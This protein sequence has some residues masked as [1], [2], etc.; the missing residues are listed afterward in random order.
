MHHRTDFTNLEA[1][2]R[3]VWT[4]ET[5]FWSPETKTRSDEERWRKWKKGRLPAFLVVTLLL[6]MRVP[7]QPQELEAAFIGRMSCV[8]TR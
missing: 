4:P 1:R 5:R 3:R 7:Q 8:T 2:T 6:Q